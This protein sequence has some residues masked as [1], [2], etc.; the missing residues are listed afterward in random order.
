MR[1]AWC[2]SESASSSRRAPGG[3]DFPVQGKSDAIEGI[4]ERNQLRLVATGAKVS[5]FVNGDEVASVSDPDP[6]EVAGRKVRFAV[7]G[8]KDGAG[9]VVGTF[10][11]V[12]IAVPNP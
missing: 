2:R 4:N 10:K 7:G 9:K 12:A 3:S 11:R 5:A 8:Q 6:G 1:C